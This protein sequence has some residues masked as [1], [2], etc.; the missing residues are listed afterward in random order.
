MFDHVTGES[1]CV[2]QAVEEP[3]A[4][5]SLSVLED[6]A[7]ILR[8]KAMDSA[9]TYEVFSEPIQVPFIPAFFIGDRAVE[10]K[11]PESTSD[12]VVSGLPEQ[13]QRLEVR[14]D[15]DCADMRHIP[16]FR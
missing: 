7:L 16:F 1:S 10:I 13:L 15:G 2:L 4:L 5:E 6:L 11:G 12:V 3:S 9:W 14:V 8:A